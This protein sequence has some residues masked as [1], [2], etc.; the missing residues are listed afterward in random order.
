MEGWM[1]HVCMSQFDDLLDGMLSHSVLMVCTNAT[2]THGLV[3]LLGMEV[4]GAKH[5]IIRTIM[6]NGDPNIG[7]QQIA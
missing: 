6:L 5:A 1:Q 2:E 4:G 3:L 7:S